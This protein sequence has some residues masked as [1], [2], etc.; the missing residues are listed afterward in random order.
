MFTVSLTSVQ[1]DYGLVVWLAIEYPMDT[2]QI[3]TAGKS[4]FEKSSW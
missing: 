2:Y 3:G 4:P 1:P